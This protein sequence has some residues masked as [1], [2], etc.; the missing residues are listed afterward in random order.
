MYVVS[1]RSNVHVLLGLAELKSLGK[2]FR[3]AVEDWVRM[4]IEEVD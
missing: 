3:L 1:P 2:L 4:K